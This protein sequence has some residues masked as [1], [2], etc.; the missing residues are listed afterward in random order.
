MRDTQGLGGNEFV[1][2]F[3][4]QRGNGLVA[5]APGATDDSSFD[6][7]PATEKPARPRDGALGDALP[8]RRAAGDD[9]AHGNRRHFNH[10]E[11]V[12]PLF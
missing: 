9:A 8:N 5:A 12:L 7:D 6:F 4:V 2:G 10:L 3:E 11:P 1:F